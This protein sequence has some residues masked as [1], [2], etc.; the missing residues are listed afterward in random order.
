MKGP[1][2]GAALEVREEGGVDLT[3][4]HHWGEAVLATTLDRMTGGTTG[5]IY[6]RMA[7]GHQDVR[8]E[9]DSM[10]VE[11]MSVAATGLVLAI[12][13]ARGGV[14]HAETGICLRGKR[15]LDVGMTGAALRMEWDATMTIEAVE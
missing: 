11:A 13:A 4:V 5:Q 3:L 9:E 6:A 1:L 10:V 2:S 14:G 8:T 7:M 12:V 15:M